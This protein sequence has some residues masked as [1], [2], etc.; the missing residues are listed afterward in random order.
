[1]GLTVTLAQRYFTCNRYR[2][3][4]ESLRAASLL[5]KKFAVENFF[6]LGSLL[7]VTEREVLLDFPRWR[8]TQR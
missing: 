3:V 8:E 5:L 1:M 2:L 6:Y 4:R 7:K